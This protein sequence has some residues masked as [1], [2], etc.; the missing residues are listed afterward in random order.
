MKRHHNHVHMGMK[1]AKRKRERDISKC[2]RQLCEYIGTTNCPDLQN[3]SRFF[4]EQ[5]QLSFQRNDELKFHKQ[6]IHEGLVFNCEICEY[7]TSRKGDFKRHIVSKH[8]DGEMKQGRK[9]SFCKEDGCTF[10][11]L[12]SNGHLRR[13]IETKHEGIVRFKCHIMNCGF[14]ASQ[15]KDL[16]RHAKTH[17]I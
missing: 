9:P 7:S 14:K 16:R 15:Y 6:K 11:D 2:R 3:H 8:S 10:I 4:C 17:T 5:C 1:R 13:H 12:K